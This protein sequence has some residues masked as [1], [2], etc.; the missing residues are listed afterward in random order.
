[1]F[2]FFIGE[3]YYHSDCLCMQAW[4]WSLL[5]VGPP[6]RAV[7]LRLVLLPNSHLP[8]RYRHCGDSDPEQGAAHHVHEDGPARVYSGP[9]VVP[10]HPGV[11]SGARLYT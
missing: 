3:L 9:Y 11:H 7:S 6:L 1:M 10:E 5:W 2:S 4:S 8:K